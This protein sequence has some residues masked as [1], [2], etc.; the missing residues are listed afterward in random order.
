MG[1]CRI[2]MRQKGG[3]QIISPFRS[4][5]KN[6]LNRKRSLTRLLQ[7]RPIYCSLMMRN[8]NAMHLITI[9]HTDTISL[10]SIAGLPAVRIRTD[11]EIVECPRKSQYNETHP[12]IT[13]P[14]RH[15]FGRSLRALLTHR[16]L[17]ALLLGGALRA[18]RLGRTLR[19]LLL[20][21]FPF[22][23]RMG[24]LFPRLGSQSPI[25]ISSKEFQLPDRCPFRRSSG[26]FSRLRPR[27]G[28]LSG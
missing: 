20:R 23:R 24:H 4:L 12:K 15:R 28:S 6:E 14:G 26:C 2:K 11:E 19:T 9:R 25:G 22:N 13:Q 7:M 18:L 10:Q 3:I 5:Q 8:V 21:N 1:T 27:R 16:L 17:R